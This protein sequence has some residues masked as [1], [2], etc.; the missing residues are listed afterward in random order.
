MLAVVI[1]YAAPDAS[2]FRVQLSQCLR[3]SPP[4]SATS[5]ERLAMELMSIAEHLASLETPD[6]TSAALF[7]KV[8]TNLNKGI[9][10]IKGLTQT[11]C[12]RWIAEGILE[13]KKHKR[14]LVQIQVR[15]TLGTL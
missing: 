2:D 6:F 4:L 13:R 3:L 15:K 9:L 5:P 12:M 8:A 7:E 11:D 1:R 14:Y 10:E